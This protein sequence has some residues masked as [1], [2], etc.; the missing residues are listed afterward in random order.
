MG[1]DIKRKRILVVSGDE[2]IR[3][4]C[5]NTLS[6]HGH[7][8]ELAADQ[9]QAL[10]RLKT[11][12]YDLVVS[13]IGAPRLDG[14]DLYIS[15]LKNHPYLKSRFLFIIGGGGADLTSFLNYIQIG[16]L[17]QPIGSTELMEAVGRACQPGSFNFS[18]KRTERRFKMEADCVVGIKPDNGSLKVRSFDI[19]RSG[20]KV[21]C[22]EDA[23]I[24]NAEITVTVDPECSG[25]AISAKVVWLRPA[26]G[27]EFEAGLRFAE[28][29]H[30]TS[31]I[32][33]AEGT[34]TAS[35]PGG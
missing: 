23:L 1:D 10:G 27:G 35:D 29:F 8:V 17:S 21:G 7:Y 4:F 20:M 31:I 26:G 32:R 28:P 34:G 18:E 9:P 12:E 11:S 25:R 19:S 24:S 30:I 33:L 6:G 3:E 14:I 16:Y 22:R 13:D 5:R 15:I 2:E